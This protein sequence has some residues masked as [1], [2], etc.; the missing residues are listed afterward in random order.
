MREILFELAQLFE[1][2][3]GVTHLVDYILDG[4]RVRALK[5]VGLPERDLEHLLLLG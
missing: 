1:K 3:P 2:D 4:V 5:G